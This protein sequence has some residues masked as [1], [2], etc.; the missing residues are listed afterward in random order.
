MKRGPPRS[1]LFPYTT[2]FRS[3]NGAFDAGEPTATT[4]ASGNYLITGVKP[5]LFK[6]RGAPQ[7]AWTTSYPN[8]AAADADA[9]GVVT[10]TA[11]SHSL[12]FTSGGTFSAKDFGNW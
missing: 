8:A 3:G 11:C 2:L 1:P 4:D 12:T 6:V 9:N 7:S 10:S 5:G